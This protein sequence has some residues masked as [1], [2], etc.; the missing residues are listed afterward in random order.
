MDIKLKLKD[1]YFLGRQMTPTN[2]Y[3]NYPTSS[4]DVGILTGREFSDE[5]QL[6]R[7][8]YFINVL[9]AKYFI[10]CLLLHF[11]HKIHAVSLL[12]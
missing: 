3:F 10:K 9:R 2:E 6:L 7:A 1:I 11:D 8:K 4:I 12:H 5:T